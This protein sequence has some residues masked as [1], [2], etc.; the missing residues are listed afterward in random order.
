MPVNNGGSYFCHTNKPIT[1]KLGNSPLIAKLK[2]DNPVNRQCNPKRL[3]VTVP[4]IRLKAINHDFTCSGQSLR[5]CVTKSCQSMTISV[6]K[7]ALTTSH[8]AQFSR[9]IYSHTNPMITPITATNNT[10]SRQVIFVFT[11]ACFPTP[12]SR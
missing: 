3:T 5:H 10:Q 2:P 4:T 12:A 1:I 6:T 9:W 8:W 7:L 11:L